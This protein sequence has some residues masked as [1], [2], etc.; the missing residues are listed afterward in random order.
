MIIT[1]QAELRFTGLSDTGEEMFRITDPR[2]LLAA[3]RVLLAKPGVLQADLLPWRP[4]AAHAP[5]MVF[6]VALDDRDTQITTLMSF[7]EEPTKIRVVFRED[8]GWKVRLVQ[9]AFEV[10]G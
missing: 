1:T 7:L 9:I 2:I 10:T 5:S 8:D 4:T 6:A 3:Q